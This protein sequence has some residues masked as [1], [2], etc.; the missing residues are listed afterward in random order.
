MWFDDEETS[1]TKKRFNEV[2]MTIGR[3]IND[4]PGAVVKTEVSQQ[5]FRL[6]KREE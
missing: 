2:D 6:I 3:C 4:R 5:N 1:V